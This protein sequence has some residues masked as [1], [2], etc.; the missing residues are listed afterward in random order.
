ME[1][2][3]NENEIDIA[4]MYVDNTY[5]FDDFY[6]EY[7]RENLYNDGISIDTL[8]DYIILYN[9]DGTD[10]KSHFM[11]IIDKDG[12]S[13]HKVYELD[14]N[15]IVMYDWTIN[16]TGI[17]LYGNISSGIQGYV[18]LPTASEINICNK[19]EWPE[20]FDENYIYSTVSKLEYTN[21]TLDFNGKVLESQTV[22][23][24]LSEFQQYDYC[25]VE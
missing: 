13:F 14:K 16:E 2:E 10:I 21:G 1:L 22:S 17:T 4:K 3:K 23:E 24:I 19:S 6:I 20:G 25:S 12:K 5:I 11:Y 18:D 9:H 8:G 15:G 7:E